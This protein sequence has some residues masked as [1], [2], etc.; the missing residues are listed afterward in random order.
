MATIPGRT[1]PASTAARLAATAQPAKQEAF[2]PLPDGFVR[3]PINDIKALESLF[4][5]Q[6]DA[7]CA[8]MV[9]CV[10]GESG[11][12]PCTAEFLAAVRRLTAECGALFMCDEIQ[13]GAYLREK[14]AALP[15]VEE[16][17]GLGLMVACDLAEGVSAPDVVLAGLDEGLLLNF[18]GPRTLR[19]LPPLVCSKEDVDVLVQKLAALLS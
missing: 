8:V 4:A 2:Q 5:T 16:V 14:L 15:Q 11:V 17:R 3:T 6:G 18:T 10:Q 7:I 19:F 13:C 1:I 9:E 12:H